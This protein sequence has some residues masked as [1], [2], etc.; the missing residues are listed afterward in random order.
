[1]GRI[2]AELAD[3]VVVTDDNPRDEDP[4][5]I[6]GA[7]LA[8]TAGADSAAEVVEIADRRE[9]IAHA[10]GWARRGDVVLVAGKGHETGQTAAGVTR[11]FDDRDEVAAALTAI[12]SGA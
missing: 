8:G 12:R 5:T 9:A 11:P 3:L 1:M 4:A 6:R 7:I 10:V 2:A